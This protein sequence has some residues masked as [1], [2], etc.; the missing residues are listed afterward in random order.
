[1]SSRRRRLA[2]ASIF[3]DIIPIG[4]S[5]HDCLS[6]AN[7]R[8]YA[9]L[10]I[11]QPSVVFSG[12]LTC[13][14]SHGKGKGSLL[15]PVTYCGFCVTLCSS[16]ILNTGECDI[17]R[18]NIQNA[19]SQ[20][21]TSTLAQSRL[22]AE[23]AQTISG[24]SRIANECSLPWI[25]SVREEKQLFVSPFAHAVDLKSGVLSL[26]PGAGFRGGASVIPSKSI[27]I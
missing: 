27:S 2:F 20:W 3:G 19:E 10:S 18:A 24:L 9:V 12:W 8:I 21:T 11:Q 14:G 16:I 15:W 23:R 22:L 6:K 26:S 17:C 4:R 25:E 7:I 1:M 5:I 13:R